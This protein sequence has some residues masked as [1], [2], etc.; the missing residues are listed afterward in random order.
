MKNSTIR[1]IFILSVI[2]AIGI[3][4]S[5]WVWLRN[6]HKL[7][8]KQFDLN[9]NIALRDV[10]LKIWELNQS[11]APVYNVV[12]KISD[13]FYI[14]QIDNNVDQE[15]LEHFLKESFTSNN[16]ITDFTFGIYDCSADSVSY[17]KYVHLNGTNEKV[18]LGEITFPKL[19]LENY[20]FGVFFPHRNDFVAEQLTL[21]TISTI[22]LI[23]T[24][25]F[26]GYIVY[27]L[28]KQKDLSDM[29]KEFVN[30]M[31]HE[32]K[33]PLATIQLAT[34]VLKKPNIS[35]KPDRIFN[36]ATIIENESKQLQRQVERVLQIARSQKKNIKITEEDIDLKELINEV[37]LAFS[38]QIENKEGTLYLN[39][40]PK[41]AIIH[42]DRLHIKNA[43]NNLLDN[44]LKYTIETPEITISLKQSADFIRL[45]VIDNGIGIKKEHQKHLFDRF[46]RV[47]TGNVHDVKGFGIGLNYVR[48]IVTA[49][50]G[51][52]EVQSREG[53]GTTF[54]LHLPKKK[55]DS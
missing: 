2:C 27:S 20:Y 15:L 51:K 43:L 36:Y 26:M 29:Q 31:T 35:E 14:V 8:D 41:P 42:G 46:Y 10:A 12:D 21:S 44:A 47:P 9:V 4:L 39:I 17:S 32:F 34:E 54:I 22:F 16:V 52:I 30:N 55:T 37:A 24:L 50:N 33:T 25:V 23:G 5:Q 6:T 7:A 45:S 49:H 11:Q 48:A 40:D 53:H 38:T 1:K 19:S 3:I 18:M 28:R 13:D